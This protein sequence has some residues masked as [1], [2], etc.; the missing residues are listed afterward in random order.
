MFQSSKRRVLEVTWE[1]CCDLAWKASRRSLHRDHTSVL[2]RDVQGAKATPN[3]AKRAPGCTS[4]KKMTSSIAREFPMFRNIS[5]RVEDVRV[6]KRE[7]IRVHKRPTCLWKICHVGTHLLTNQPCLQGNRSEFITLVIFHPYTY[8]HKQHVHISTYLYC[9]CILC[10]FIT[11]FFKLHIF[12]QQNC[13]PNVTS[14]RMAWWVVD[15]KNK[16]RPPRSTL[17]LQAF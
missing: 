4:E 10:N 7:K 9:R 11:V 14:E 6:H 5:E 12:H 2:A 16:D 3:R 15:P 1:R 17:A 8:K 13:F